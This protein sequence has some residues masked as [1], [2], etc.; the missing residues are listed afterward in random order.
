MKLH[1]DQ[2]PTQQSCTTPRT[3]L[4]TLD[5][6]GPIS[7]RSFD[8]KIP[9]STLQGLQHISPLYYFKI[10]LCAL[11]SRRRGFSFTTSDLLLKDIF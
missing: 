6:F 9:L 4:Y 7:L 10:L 1:I 11:R 5:D 3:R 2:L 8:L